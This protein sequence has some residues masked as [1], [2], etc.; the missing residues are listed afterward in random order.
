MP[1]T[2]Q[3]Y[4]KK[5]STPF[6][7]LLA[8][9]FL[10]LLY[11]GGIMN[12]QLTSRNSAEIMLQRLLWFI[13]FKNN[14]LLL[15]VYLV[16]LAWAFWSAKKQQMVDFKFVYFPYSVFE[17]TLYALLLSVLAGQLTA[18]TSIGIS[19]LLQKSAGLPSAEVGARM[20]SALGAGIY[21]ELLFRFVI[22]SVLLFIFEK[23]SGAKRSVNVV[24]SLV[25]SA[26]LFSGFH[27]LG[28][29]EVMTL[30]SFAFRFYAGMILGSLF[31]LRGIGIASYTHAIYNLLL[32]LR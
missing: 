5:T 7:G 22:I 6:F 18:R 32:V 17:S 30:E 3:V 9:L 29:R 13:G 31:V 26:L 12:L 24:F 16:L 19:M 23:L 11:E 15:L 8:I 20:M 10:L 28:G 1:A 25:I 14:L 4:F 27:Y 2:L 21:E